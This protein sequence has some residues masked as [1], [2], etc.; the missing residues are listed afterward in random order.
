MA[1]DLEPRSADELQLAY[2]APVA[3]STPPM[4]GPR[5]FFWRAVVAGVANVGAAGTLD[6]IGYLVLFHDRVAMDW[7]A[8]GSLFALFVLSEGLAFG[9]GTGGG[10][11][12][13]DAIVARVHPKSPRRPAAAVIGAT[14]GGAIAVVIPSAIGTLYFGS[15][16]A[17]FMGTAAIA[18]VPVVFVLSASTMIASADARVRD[19]SPKRSSLI[20]YSFAAVTPLAA[21]AALVT[22][23]LDD[24]SVPTWARGI[25]DADAGPEIYGLGLFVVGAILGTALGAALGLHVGVTTAVTRWRSPERRP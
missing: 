1:D 8:V 20:G 14:I 15:K 4:F 12:A 24:D 16:R 11:I 10:I 6:G 23:S 22:A 19:V 25:A 18:I 7:A 17:P 5:E 13:A 21:L 3:E 2:A 9:A